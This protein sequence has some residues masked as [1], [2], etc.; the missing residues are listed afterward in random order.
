MVEKINSEEY[1]AAQES[2]FDCVDE[3]K[4]EF[5][6]SKYVI[7]NMLGELAKKVESEEE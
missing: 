3:I 2:V 4:E 7:A 6:W 1:E 5:R